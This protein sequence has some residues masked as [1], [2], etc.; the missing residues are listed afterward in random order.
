MPPRRLEPLRDP[1]H[2]VV[3]GERVEARE[4]EP[5]AVAL[6]AA[7]RLV[8]GRSVKYH[9]PR[10]AACFLGRCDGCLMRVEGMQSVMTCRAPACD[11]LHVETQNVVGSARRDLLAATDWFFPHGMNHHEMFTWNE[12][13]NRIMQKIARRIAG[14]GTLPDEVL[15]PRPSEQID[16]DVLVVGGGPAGT[17]AATSCASRGLRVTLVDE[18]DALGGS[19]RWWPGESRDAIE[20]LGR[21][22]ERAGVRVLSCS[23]ALA[24]YD[25]WEDVAGAGDPPIAAPPRR[26]TNAVVAVDTGEA[27]LRVRP[28]RLVIA[29]GRHEGAS[30]F[31]GADTPGVVNFAGA[32]VLLAHGVLVGEDVVVVGEGERVEALARALEEAGA[33]VVGPVPEASVRRVRGRPSVHGVEL[34]RDGE[35][36]HH[37]C[38][39]VVVASPTSAVFELAAQAGVNVTWSG[40]GYELEADPGDGRTAAPDV[41]VI[42]GA[43]GVL[44]L[45]AARAQAERAAEAIARELAS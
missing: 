39:A 29:T 1:V 40:A 16:V 28:R 35:V 12:Q 31:E 9:R 21:E 42:G 3:D 6:T 8:L 13:V 37:A 38:D 14:I 22:A 23:S 2:L 15:A 34:E 10:G 11:G 30:A 7:G 4:G 25:P 33:G 17:A 45:D 20:E 27:L 19:L 18:E 43:A 44:D 5:V 24:V 36:E 26:E 32:C 41:R